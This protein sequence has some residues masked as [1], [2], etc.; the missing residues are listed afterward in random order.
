MGRQEVLSHRDGLDPLKLVAVIHETALRQAVGSPQILRDQLDA[1]VERS[2]VPNVSLHVL[3]FSARPVFT[4]TCMYAYFEYDDMLEQD[5]VR[6][7]T[8]AGFAV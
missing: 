2:K 6:I 4:I 1:L 3:P 5:A 8:H 7:E